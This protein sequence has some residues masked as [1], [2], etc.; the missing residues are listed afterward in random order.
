M[1]SHPFSSAVERIFAGIPLLV[2]VLGYIFLIGPIAVIVAASLSGGQEIQFPPQHLSFSLYSQF[3]ADPTWWKPAMQSVLVALLTSLLALVVTLPA[4]YALNRCCFTGM[5]GFELLFISP[6]LIPVVALGLGV[7]IFFSGVRLDNS[8]PGLVLTHSTLVMPFMFIS[9]SAGMRHTD[10]TLESVAV[11]MGAGPIRTFFRVLMPQIRT[12]IL[13]GLL[14]AFLISFDEVVIA[15][16]I[17]GPETTTLP[18]R[19][20]S[21]L[22]WEV[23]PV[24]TAISSMLTIASLVFCLGILALKESTQKVQN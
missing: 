14:F 3:F 12:S 16:F 6:M 23:S 4:A 1:T 22:R 2:A 9:I 5:K 13:V 10:P 17:T 18:V 20:Y 21:A 8:V 24:L 11:L 15:Y 7:Y 19:M